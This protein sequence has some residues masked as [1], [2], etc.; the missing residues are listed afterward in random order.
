MKYFPLQV[1]SGTP[2]RQLASPSCFPPSNP[3]NQRGHSLKRYRAYIWFPLTLASQEDS[4]ET[5]D[6]HILFD[7]HFAIDSTTRCSGGIGSEDLGDEWEGTL[8]YECNWQR[9]YAVQRE[10]VRLGSWS[11][12]LEITG[13]RTLCLLWENVR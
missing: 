6:D 10:S 11:G 8:C 1:K 2:P 13:T 5:T 4:F 3:T 7:R 12:R 9:R